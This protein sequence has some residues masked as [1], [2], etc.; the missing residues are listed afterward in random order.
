MAD[1]VVIKLITRKPASES[2]LALGILCVGNPTKLPSFRFYTFSAVSTA[3]ALTSL[4]DATERCR[5]E[6]VRTDELITALKTLL[7]VALVRC[8]F[9]Q[10]WRALGSDTAEGRWQTANASYN[11]ILLA[12]ERAVGK[13]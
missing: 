12:L 7:A 6:D 2:P 9:E 3:E 5:N 10:Y 8:P 1:S 11:A 4:A 13:S